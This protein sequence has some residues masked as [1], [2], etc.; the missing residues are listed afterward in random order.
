MECFRFI[1]RFQ[2]WRE[3]LQVIY[4]LVK[5]MVEHM[6]MVY[7]EGKQVLVEEQQ[8]IVD[9]NPVTIR[10]TIEG[11]HTNPVHVTSNNLVYSKI[12]VIRSIMKFNS[13]TTNF[14]LFCLYV[15]PTHVN[16]I[17]VTSK[18]PVYPAFSITSSILNF[19][20]KT[21]RTFLCMRNPYILQ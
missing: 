1:V 9:E 11:I 6:D 10:P 15:M 3:E 7:I 21:T 18:P 2:S 13:K 12:F 19:T 14:L 17:Q 5:N 4:G 20:S 16:P 8:G